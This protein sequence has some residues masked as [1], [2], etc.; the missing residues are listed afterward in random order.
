MENKNNFNVTLHF[1]NGPYVEINS[2]IESE[3][4]VKFIDKDNN[5]IIHQPI[6]KNNMYSKLNIQYFV[7]WR[8]EIYKEDN[9]VFEYDL[10]FKGQRILISFDAFA[11]GDNIAWFPYLEEFRKK[12]DC[13]VIASTFW[14]KL[15]VCKYPQIEFVE[16]G[17]FV[18][19]LH[20]MYS[21]GWFFNREIEPEIPNTIP[22]QKSMSNI[23]G[24]EFKEI[25]PEIAFIPSER[26]YQ[27]KYIAISPFSTAKLKHWNNEN[28]WKELIG[29]LIDKGYK[30]VNVSKEKYESDYVESIS[31]T[32]IENAMNVI[33]HSEF[34][35]GLSSGL[36]WLS[37]ALGKH[38][39]M[40]SNFTEK[41]H[42][43]TDNCT[44]IINE[45]VCHGCWNMKQYQFKRGDFNWC[46]IL[47]NTEK[48]FE[49][50]K[51]I[52]AQMVINQI[53]HLIKNPTI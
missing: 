44:R 49:C 46:P 30:I 39:V 18:H 33:H 35:I 22:L 53:Q 25:K 9:L 42:E 12:H 36:S 2:K 7:N 4:I 28:G 14:N 5:K 21:G 11:L 26:P 40:I 38:V 10:N 1:M 51:S 16:P 6:L 15:F 8:I 27:E 24:I 41:D 37:W 47:G 13:H 31:D 48:E 19:D 52:T 17:T 3:F 43:F 20:G 45:S 29:Y 32:S 50:H 23:L 34:F